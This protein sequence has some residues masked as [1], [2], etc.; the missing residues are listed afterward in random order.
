[1]S[2]RKRL[3]ETW[4]PRILFVLTLMLS[5][6]LAGL[7]A[8]ASWIMAWCGY[9][10]ILELFARDLTVRRTTLFSSAGLAVTAFAFFKP[11][12]KNHNNRKTPPTNFAGA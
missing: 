5:L 6:G 1:M 11:S 3:A 10:P 4:V 7:V 2:L 8:F 12:I 9:S